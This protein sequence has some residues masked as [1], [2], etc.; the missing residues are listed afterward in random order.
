MRANAEK[1]E[2][3]AKDKPKPEAPKELTFAEQLQ[4]Q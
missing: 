3:A 1:R 4:Q 2:K